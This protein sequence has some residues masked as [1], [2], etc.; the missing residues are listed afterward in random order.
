MVTGHQSSGLGSD[1]IEQEIHAEDHELAREA[2]RLRLEELIQRR[3]NKLTELKGKQVT[4]TEIANV[5]NEFLTGI[6]DVAKIDPGRAKEFLN[7]L[8][9]EDISKLSMLSSSAKSSGNMATLLPF[10]KSEK[11]DIKDIVAIVKMMQP[12]P[13]QDTKMSE[14]AALIKALQPTTPKQQDS[15]VKEV[16]AYLQPFYE[17]MSKKDQAFYT[18]QIEN[19]KSQI[20]DPVAYLQHLKEVAPSLGFT[21]GGNSSQDIELTKM[22]LDQE[23]W[24]L[25]QQW[26]MNKELAELTNEKQSKKDQWKLIEKIAVPAIKQLQPVLNAAINAGKQKLNTVAAKPVNVPAKEAATAFLCPK[27]AE[28]DVQ[29]VIDVSHNPDV[30]VCT[31]CNAE[32]PKSKGLD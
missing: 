13:Q 27:C 23:K 14:I 8:T 17:M 28:N 20:V 32:F 19:V 31:T 22:K 6:F 3:Q 18:A 5:G 12:P 10:L 9:Q 21:Q 24:K 2:R 7:S 1:P 15:T 26:R 25:E 29:T 16:M 30:A 11:T 4:Q